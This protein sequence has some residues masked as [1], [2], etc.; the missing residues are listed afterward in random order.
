[1]IEAENETHE[2]HTLNDKNSDKLCQL[3]IE[4][5]H[6]LQWCKNENNLK[7]LKE[8]EM[9][10]ANVKSQVQTRL[11]MLSAIEKRKVKK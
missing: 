2:L 5:I 1:M 11:N 9:K 4:S 3:V 10:N 7:I 8:K 6:W